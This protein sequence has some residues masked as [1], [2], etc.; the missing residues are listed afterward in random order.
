MLFSVDAHAGLADGSITRTFRTWKRLQVK[1]GGRYRVGEMLL[2]VDQVSRVR[3]GD[4]S[5]ADA[6]AA[7]E[8]DLHALLKRLGA[9]RSE[10]GEVW[11]I[12]LHYAGP[13][14]RIALR[15]DDRLGENDLARLRLRLD[16]LDAASA[17]GPWTLDVLRLIAARPEIVSTE[18]AAERG[19]ERQEFK[20]DVRKLKNLG[21]TES[22][23]VGYRLSARGRALLASLAT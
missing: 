14:D 9:D 6:Y 11:R 15:A 2:E 4:L 23:P 8:S 18:L 12:D 10:S 20:T 22:L 1:P 19:K 7:G 16:R 5:E 13:D 17:S 21:L 3:I